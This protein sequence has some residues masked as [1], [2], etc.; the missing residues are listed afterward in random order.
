MLNVNEGRYN[1][2][3]DR[4]HMT[5]HNRNE[6][7]RKRTGSNRHED[8]D[9][10]NGSNI[11]NECLKTEFRNCSISI[12]KWQTMHGTPDERMERDNFNHFHRAKSTVRYAND[13]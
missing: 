8:N 7:N 9:K 10:S 5:N 1:K 13:G 6:C 3:G 12:Y 11:R 2:Y 4:M